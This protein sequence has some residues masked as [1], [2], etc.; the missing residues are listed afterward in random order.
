M[1]LAFEDVYIPGTSV[2]I[3]RTLSKLIEKGVVRGRILIPREFIYFFE[4]MARNGSA[5]GLLGLEELSAIRGA[6][7]EEMG[8]SIEVIDSGYRL[9][10]QLDQKFL[11]SLVV[12]IAKRTG[13]KVLTHDKI[14][15][16]TCKTL[17]VDAML[18]E[19]SDRGL[20][21]FEKYF[22]SET[23]SLHIKEGAPIMAKKGK[24]GEWRLA[25]IDE[26]PVK[27]NDVELLIEEI[28]R[29]ARSGDGFIETE[30]QGLML[31]QLGDYR[32]VVVSPPINTVYEL[33][34]TRPIV[35]LRLED[36]NLPE[37]L[38]RRL[39]EK[40]EGILIAGAPGMGKTTFAQALAEYYSRKGKI[41]KTS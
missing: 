25:I 4:S 17:N 8:I 29:R 6:I 15:Y 28:V 5:V 16:I 12:D 18:I 1:K 2:I 31:I 24:P 11:D 34:I 7:S 30:K 40:A 10:L 19:Y 36:Y 27:R 38:I 14:Q 22:D 37:K 21:W 33:T 13:A 32:I 9:P 3:E 20:L 23:L 39:D 41:V 35:R 26:N